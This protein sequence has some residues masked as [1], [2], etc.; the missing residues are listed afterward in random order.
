MHLP[1]ETGAIRGKL[2]NVR[3]TGQPGSPAGVWPWRAARSASKTGQLVGLVRQGRAR[4][5]HLIHGGALLLFGTRFKG[6]SCALAP[7]PGPPPRGPG[8]PST[9]SRRA[10]KGSGGPGTRSYGYGAPRTPSALCL[11]PARG[12]L[13]ALAYNLEGDSGL[14]RTRKVGSAWHAV[15]AWAIRHLISPSRHSPVSRS[16][17]A[18]GSASG[19]WCC[20]STPRTTPRGA[21]PR[22]APSATAT[23]CSPTPAPR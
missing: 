17:W 9:R 10:P 14:R 19:W 21:P 7:A 8:G 15:L 1:Q 16:G 13:A 23:R 2:R 5:L 18:T 3:G 22:R 12:R 11:R 20:T 4:P 6:A